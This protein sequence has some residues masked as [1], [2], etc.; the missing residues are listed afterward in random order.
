[1]SDKATLLRLLREHR[2]ATSVKKTSI[3]EDEIVGLFDVVRDEL[4]SRAETAEATL[5]AA[6]DFHPRAMKL[7]RKRKSFLVV[8]NDEPYYRQVYDLIRDHEILAGTWTT[9]DQRHYENALAA[10]K[11]GEE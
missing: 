5:Q 8:A 11:G 9:S 3:V 2:E 1:M 4:Q 6:T 7:I 10:L